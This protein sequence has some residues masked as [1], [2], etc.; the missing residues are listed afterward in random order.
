MRLLQLDP[1]TLW[2]SSTDKPPAAAWMR[3]KVEKTDITQALAEVGNKVRFNQLRDQIMNATECSKRTAQLAIAEACQQGWIAR[4]NGQYHCRSSFRCAS[5]LAAIDCPHGVAPERMPKAE[6]TGLAP[7]ES[8]D[9]TPPAHDSFCAGGDG[10][11][12]S[13][14]FLAAS[15]FRA[16]PS[17]NPLGQNQVHFFGEVS[18]LRP[19][20]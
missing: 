7:E 6:A 20:A 19:W 8:A 9:Y 17:A 18:E 1:R 4:A 10:W 3:R 12:C 11:A 5:V 13:L 14:P 2:F 15:T 16:H